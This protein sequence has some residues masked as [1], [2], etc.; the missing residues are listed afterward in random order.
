MTSK[1]RVS[2]NQWVRRQASGPFEKLA[3]VFPIKRGPITERTVVSR[4]EHAGIDEGT[5]RKAYQ[6]Y[7]AQTE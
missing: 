7:V 1:T 5:A 3:E 4:A 6:A 2:F